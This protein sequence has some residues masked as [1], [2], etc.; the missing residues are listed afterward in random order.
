[1]IKYLFFIIL[2]MTC[3][4][5]SIA[6][7]L[8]SG[9]FKKVKNDKV[10]SEIVNEYLSSEFVSKKDAIWVSVYESSV[11][12]R[13]YSFYLCTTPDSSVS[14]YYA[15][16][17]EHN[18][19]GQIVKTF[20]DLLDIILEAIPIEEADKAI[21]LIQFY[22]DVPQY[23][24]IRNPSPDKPNP[25]IVEKKLSNSV[26]AIFELGF[27]RQSY[28]P[29]VYNRY[30]L[31]GY[32]CAEPND[33]FIVEKWHLLVY[34]RR[35]NSERYDL[36]VDPQGNGQLS[37]LQSELNGKYAYSFLSTSKNCTHVYE[38]SASLRQSKDCVL[39]EKTVIFNQMIREIAFFSES[40]TVEKKYQLIKEITNIVKTIIN[41][42][43]AS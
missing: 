20:G 12:C 5:P 26:T 8:T 6:Q 28:Y 23:K 32:V 42:T 37:I 35:V 3:W 10:K 30:N 11:R 27:G 34:G 31:D 33:I 14:T 1:M 25:T 40:L 7:N 16:Y 41:F 43:K 29:I 9:L 39:F 15:V 13:G 17:V 38:M 4:V 22:L 21:S 24:G 2:L 18:G 36:F 19:M